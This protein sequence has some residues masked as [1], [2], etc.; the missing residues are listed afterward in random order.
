M[1]YLLV[2]DHWIGK[3]SDKY[4]LIW[5]LLYISLK[6]I[7]ISLKQ[8]PYENILQYFPPNWIKG[9]SWYL[10]IANVLS[11][12]TPIFS[13]V[14]DKFRKSDQYLICYVE[15]R[16]DDPNNVIVIVYSFR[17]FT[18]PNSAIKCRTYQKTQKLHKRLIIQNPV[19]HIIIWLQ[20]SYI[21]WPSK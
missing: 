5:T 16:N 2:L 12:W 21:K 7:L 11:H 9:L 13:P 19:T 8:N 20:I 14:S 18:W 6:H 15:T 10:W 4:L 1:K 17:R 3:W